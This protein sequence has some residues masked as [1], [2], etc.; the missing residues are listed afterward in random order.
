MLQTD[1][2]PIS[3]ANA[4]MV[5]TS[6][7]PDD[8]V[9]EISGD[10]TGGI[11][12]IAAVAKKLQP[13]LLAS[14]KLP[15][16]VSA[17]TGNI[18]VNL[19]S[20]TVVDAAGVQKSSDFALN[21]VVQDFASTAPIE[22]YTINN[23][24]LS[25]QASQAGYRVR[26]QASINDLAA[27]LTIE[28]QLE[29]GAPPHDAEFL[30]QGCRPGQDG[31]RRQPVPDREAGLSPSRTDGTVDIALDLKDAALDMKDLGITKDKGIA[32]EPESHHQAAGD[33]TNISD[34]ISASAM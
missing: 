22:G 26:G 2:G 5:M 27:N 20:T 14:D 6:D 8:Q 10:L 34:V 30:C 19:L 11:P 3:I 4:A 17:L 31:F 23:G 9:V 32:G 18:S 16:D 21:G 7:S 29:G 24:Q 12:A 1:K 33:V 13:D 28:G 15:L 25:F